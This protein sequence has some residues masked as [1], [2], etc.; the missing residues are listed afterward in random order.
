MIIEALRVRPT[1][2]QEEMIERWERG[3]E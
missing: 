3:D 1:R 2:E